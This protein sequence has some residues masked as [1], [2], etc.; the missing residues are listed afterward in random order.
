MWQFI[1]GCIIGSVIGMLV[2]SLCTINKITLLN[3]LYNIARDRA[4]DGDED[5]I[6]ILN[7][8]YGKDW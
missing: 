7:E 8:Y 3:S 6:N 1:L 2:M 4:L 5:F